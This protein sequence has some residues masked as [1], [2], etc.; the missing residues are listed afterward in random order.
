MGARRTVDKYRRRLGTGESG[1]ALDA[2]YF[3]RDYDAAIEVLEQMPQSIINDEGIVYPKSLFLGLMRLAKGDSVA[4]RIDFGAAKQTLIELIAERP[5]DHR[6]YSSLGLAQAGLGDFETGVA[7]GRKSVDMYPISKDTTLLVEYYYIEDYTT[8]STAYNGHYLHS[9]TRVKS[10]KGK[11]DF[12]AG[13]LF[14]PVNQAAN[15]FIVQVLEPESVDSYFNWN[16]FD[17]ILSRKEYFSPYVFDEKAG[18]ILDNDP[19]LKM[20]FK[21]KQDRDTAFAND[22]YLQLKFIY[23]RSPYSEKSLLRYPVARYYL[24]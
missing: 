17:P 18:E 13:D 19:K 1:I 21:S 4:A 8:T 6:L 10:V 11:I 15:E 5:D 20:E 9:Q 14:I 7:N 23:E 12:L 24:E 2:L 3:S 16:F 22:H